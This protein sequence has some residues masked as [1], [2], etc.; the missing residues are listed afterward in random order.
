VDCQNAD[1]PSRIDEDLF[2]VGLL[3][4]QTAII[5]ADGEILHKLDHSYRIV[6]RYIVGTQ[7]IY[8]FD[9]E[10]VYDIRGKMGTVI[11]IMEN[12][13]Y[14]NEDKGNGY[15]IV[16]FRDGETRTI[17]SYN[18]DNPSG[19]VFQLMEPAHCYMIYNAGSGEFSY[20]N[21]EDEHITNSSK[22]LTLRHAS[23]S[24]SSYLMWNEDLELIYCI[25][26]NTAE[27]VEMSFTMMKILAAGYIAMEVTQC[28]SG[29]MRG[30]G[31]TVTPMWISIFNTVILRI[32]AAYLLVWLTKSPELP[33]GD[34]R[35][36]FV[37]LLITWVAG[38]CITFA[39]YRAGRWK[40][41]AIVQ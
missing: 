34:C 17:F 29:V 35:M 10:K 3:T 24:H 27:L 36:M 5:R 8:N 20:Y 22:L 6:D 30:A 12:T 7:A 41:K 16:T 9:L 28:L 23:E 19:N 1:I 31:D 37:S 4:G 15:D 26:T 13:V 32:P 40:G 11:G 25:F 39:M 2:T 21:S 14:I 33:Q 18:M 38:A